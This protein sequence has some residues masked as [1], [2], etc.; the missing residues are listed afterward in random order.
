MVDCWVRFS[1]SD[2]L[3]T[4][5]GGMGIPASLSNRKFFLG[6]FA[7]LVHLLSALYGEEV[8][9]QPA[10]QTRPV[11]E[12]RIALVIG[13]GAY[14]EAPLPNALNDAR[15][16]AKSLGDLGFDVDYVED[17]SRAKFAQ[18]LDRFRLR[19]QNNKAVA[20]F[21]YAGHG[22]QAN[23]R[24]YLLPI[25]TESISDE[26]SVSQ[27]AIDLQI[28]LRT[29]EAS[30][31]GLNVVILD[32]CR[33]NPFFGRLKNPAA[34]F[35]E[36]DGPLNTIIAYSTAPG[37]VSFDGPTG[38]N[39]SYTRHLVA[40]FTT[41]GLAIDRVFRRVRENVVADTN[42]LQRPWEN[43]SLMVEDFYLVPASSGQKRAESELASEEST[44]WSQV[45]ESNNA[46]EYL[47]YLRRFPKGNFGS[48]AFKKL[49]EMLT[50]LNAPNIVESELESFL[51]VAYAGFD[52]RPVN[53]FSAK[54]LGLP[55][56]QGAIVTK[57]EPNSIA[58]SAGLQ[59]GD[60]LLEV[61]GEPVEANLKM[62]L[63]LATR[64]RPGEIVVGKIWRAGKTLELK[65]VVGRA[66][67]DALL[68]RVSTRA[69]ADKKY[70]RAFQLMEYF[71]DK[72]SSAKALLGFYL[73]TGL[74]GRTDAKRG[75]TLLNEAMRDEKS[76]ALLLAASAHVT[77][78]AKIFD[79]EVALLDQLDKLAT[80]GLPE[81]AL[82]ANVVAL[83]KQVPLEGRAKI[84]SRAEY[85]ANL[86]EPFSQAI[87]ARMLEIGYGGTT[88]FESARRWNESARNS[89]N[90][91]VIKIIDLLRARLNN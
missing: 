40:N 64:F 50:R 90:A 89:K 43:S 41:P 9:A 70:D 74:G 61:N 79:D 39:S 60:V 32:A 44:A 91:E 21:Y 17:T 11:Q 18:A 42:S 38:G 71:V 23:R 52:G 31:R 72:K 22:L 86:G 34:G 59:V 80:V 5:V 35:A 27:V 78:K 84:R 73:V 75:V 36:V 3:I 29:M 55:K 77:G 83:R 68:W 12:N 6:A 13:N 63:E 85:G 1:L 82:L 54:Y 8:L 10:S 81:A 28:V 51:G 57:V 30:N 53:E 48:A 58:E 67:I 49:N 37:T 46:F 14:S 25:S 88:D 15:L 2:F 16:V 7:A 47:E 87:L 45:R 20:L 26:A 33:N 56:T 24:N 65:G 69:V 76:S 4:F 19:L 66:T 62:F